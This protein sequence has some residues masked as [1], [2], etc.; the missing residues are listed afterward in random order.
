MPSN[1]V[2]TNLPAIYP[3]NYDM[4]ET[5]LVGLGEWKAAAEAEGYDQAKIEDK[6]IPPAL[7][8]LER[9]MM[10]HILPVRYVSQNM[11]LTDSLITGSPYN[12]KRFP[13]TTLRIDQASG[14]MGFHLPA[15]PVIEIIRL[16][17]MI[18]PNTP[19]FHIPADWIYVEPLTGYVTIQPATPTAQLV[20]VSYGMMG[21]SM[22]AG[23]RPMVPQSLEIVFDAGLPEG[24][25]SGWEHQDLARVASQFCAIKVLEDLCEIFDP[26]RQ[27]VSGNAFGVNTNVSYERFVRKRGEL[28]R[29]VEMWISEYREN[30]GGVYVGQM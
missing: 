5:H 20:S 25:E 29:N 4:V 24:W 8:E 7:R 13:N 12:Y 17:V 2:A 15:N 14:F 26:G 6:V 19:A 21:L 1:N 22:F 30:N 9:K 23:D 18:N 3:V 10:S 16:R 27:S 28:E 11:A